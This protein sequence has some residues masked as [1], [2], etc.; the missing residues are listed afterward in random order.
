MNCSPWGYHLIYC[1]LKKL[2]IPFLQVDVIECED[3]NNFLKTSRSNVK[4]QLVT[5]KCLV[6]NHLSTQHLTTPQRVSSIVFQLM[7][8]SHACA[9]GSSFS[10]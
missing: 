2:F 6:L 1:A 4:F 5:F 3:G 9:E 8:R 10:S 7:I